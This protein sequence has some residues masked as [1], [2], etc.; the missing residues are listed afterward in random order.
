MTSPPNRPQ[1]GP[2]DKA[3]LLAYIRENGDRVAKR[4]IAKAFNVKGA[5][6]IALKQMLRELADEGHIEKS[7][8]RGVRGEGG[9]PPVALLEAVEV[10]AVGERLARPAN[11]D[12]ETPPPTIVLAPWRKGD[13]TIGIGDRF[14]G[15][16]RPLDDQDDYAF[17]AKIIKKLGRGSRRLL[18]VFVADRKGGRITPVDKRG[19]D[20]FIVEAPDVG[21]AADGELVEAELLS[22]HRY[23]LRRARVIDRLGDPGA[24]K[25]ISLIAVH[26]HGLPVEFSEA[27]LAEASAAEELAVFEDRQDLR[28]LPLVT[29]DPEDARDHDDAVFAALDDDPNNPKGWVVWVAI[30]DVAAYVRPGSELD[31][32]AR[33]RGNSAYFPDRVVPMLPERLSGDLC[34]LHEDVD[35]PC[36]AVRMVLSENGDKRGHSFHRAVMRSRA[37][38]TYE[39]AQQAWEGAP[40]AAAEPLLDTVITPLF[41]AYHAAAAARERRS[42]LDLDLPERRVVLG[43]D[44]QVSAI[45]F[46]DRFDAHRVI[47]EF[48][49]LANVCAAEALEA[50]R[51]RL[52]Y[53]VH[54]E[55]NPEKLDALREILGSIDISLAKGQVMTPRLLNRAL[56]AAAGTEHAELVNI[57]VLRA[58]TQAYYYP[59]NF[60]HFGLALP[61]YAHFTSPIRRYAD[62]I[63]HRALIAGLKLGADWRRDGQTDA[64]SEELAATAEHVSMTERRA[65]AAERDTVDRYLAAY[66][67]DRRGAI[68]D[69]RISGVQRFG[70]FVKLAESG[71][72]G[73]APMA[74]LGDE[75]F[76]YDDRAQKL[77]GERSGVELQVGQTVRARLVEA[78]PAS[79]GLILELVDL[80]KLT[81]SARATRKTRPATAVSRRVSRSKIAKAK[82]SRKTKR[83]T[84]QRSK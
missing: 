4:D 74:M 72:D 82:A 84:A 55:P 21:G 49:I 58:Q 6:R 19:A 56:D 69:G 16:L 27:V 29:I 41:R 13:P 1:A 40:D 25:A 24:S 60:G 68:F 48:M 80:P 64:E 78:T 77:V 23:G 20:A 61:R 28:D 67:A 11:W 30:A 46:R 53:R 26:E 57:S 7:G 75:R 3:A 47:E 42:P 39:Q 34:S 62:L 8:R 70:L 63:V 51:M 73:F 33:T 44:G 22:G 71:A 36:L 38:L 65:M 59:E 2:P 43:A 9:L 10:D 31:R 17:E 50:A 66:L 12:R 14:L 81:R 32:A 54:E 5:D 79:G 37:S 76:R 52:L 18:G 45:R 35:R 83:K 15:R